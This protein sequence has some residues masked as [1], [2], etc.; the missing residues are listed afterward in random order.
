MNGY[1]EQFTVLIDTCD[2]CDALRRNMPF[3][4]ADTGLIRPCWKARILHETQ[5]AIFESAKRV[6]DGSNLRTAIKVAFPEPL[7]AGHEVSEGK[8]DL[9]DPDDN[10]VLAAVI[11]ADLEI[12][13]GATM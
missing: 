8:P 1:A 4:L 12:S 9:P 3:S 7:T 6:T 5:K 11:S 2:M 13:P 10:H